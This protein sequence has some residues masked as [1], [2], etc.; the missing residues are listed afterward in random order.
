LQNARAYVLPSLYEGFG[1]PVLEAIEANIPVVISNN[2]SLPEVGGKYAFYIE[3][4]NSAVQIANSIQKVL[5]LSHTRRTEI[6]CA[7]KAWIT[8][9]NWQK[10]ANQTLS[11]LLEVAETL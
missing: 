10:C 4:P 7:A 2:S 6:T 3:D 1:I 9:F 5:Q 8:K 11:K